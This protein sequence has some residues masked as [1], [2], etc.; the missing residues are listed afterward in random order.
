M[1]WNQDLF[2][3]NVLRLLG[4]RPQNALNKVA[5]RDAVT[6]WKKGAIPS[7]E[8][9]LKTAAFFKCSLDDLTTEPI[10]SH[11]KEE[12]TLPGSTDDLILMLIKEQGKRIDDT[13]TKMNQIVEVVTRYKDEVDRL[14]AVLNTKDASLSTVNE[15]IR[16]ITVRLMNMREDM[17]LAAEKKDVTLLKKAVGG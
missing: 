12:R 8:V 14:W 9:L 15:S 1:E 6:R 7:R 2:V 3:K 16:D 10:T 13:Q 11:G 5:G 4:N 17:N